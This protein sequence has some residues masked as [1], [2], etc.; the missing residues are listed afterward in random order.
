MQR[1]LGEGRGLRYIYNVGLSCIQWRAS[2][3][4]DN[5]AATRQYEPFQREVPVKYVIST[6]TRIRSTWGS[7]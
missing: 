7:I 6:H 3:T 2:N 1:L 4:V 5:G